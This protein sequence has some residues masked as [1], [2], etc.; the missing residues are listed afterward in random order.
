MAKLSHKRLLEVLD[1]DPK[2]GDFTWRKCVGKVY[3]GRLAGSVDAVGYRRIAIDGERFFAHRLAWFYVYKAWP[4]HQVD[5]INVNNSDNRISNLR[6]AT[7]S[8][9]Q[10]NKPLN[11]EVSTT[12]FKGVSYHKRQKR[13][14][15][16]I[17]VNKK[18]IHLG[19]F[20]SAEDAHKAYVVAANDI[21][22]AFA[23]V[24]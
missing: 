1:Y 24:A 19:C 7:P 6:D 3:E 20:K 14:F 22:G 10:A 13:Y 9:N 12:G 23:R 8:Q 11:R 5:H 16:R 17:R 4:I 18:L 2:T 15:A 21:H